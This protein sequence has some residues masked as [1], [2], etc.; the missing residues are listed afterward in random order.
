M[1]IEPGSPAGSSIV[2]WGVV[3]TAGI[4]RHQVIPAMQQGHHTKV[5]AIASR[6]LKKARDA[7]AQLGIETAH[8]SYEDLLADPGVDAVYIPLPNH[9]HVPWSLKALD[10]GKHVLCEKPI[11]MDAAD[12]ARLAAA[13]S[14]HPRL[15]VMEAFMYR[16]HSQWQRARELVQERAIGEVKAIHTWFSYFND[17][18]KNVRNKVDCGGGALMDI[19]C[20]GVSVA[21]FIFEREPRQA[22]AVSDRDPNF[23]TDRL[24]SAAMDFGGATATFTCATQLTRHQRVEIVGTSGRIEIELPFNPPADRRSRIWVYRGVDGERVDFDLCNQYTRQGD[25]FS[26]AI[27]GSTGVPTPLADAVANMRA[28]DAVRQS[29]ARGAAISISPKT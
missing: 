7:A 2:R 17:D 4:A 6:D 29:A 5:T 10:A 20:Y 12:A 26:A 19:G 23:Q 24:T 22:T 11:G 21:R 16:F 13:A 27:L 9:L 14:K 3:G 1:S 18:P 8:G 15:K 28:M 25:L